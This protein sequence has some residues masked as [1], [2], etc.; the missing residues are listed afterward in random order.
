MEAR[1]RKVHD[2]T[3]ARSCGQVKTR[4][5]M[6]ASPALSTEEIRLN[7]ATATKTEHFRRLGLD[8]K[9]C[10]RRGK[11]IIWAEGSKNVP[12]DK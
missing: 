11:N 6:A 7:Q 10:K 1:F 5:A 2:K 3:L 8:I 12:S 4:A 9:Q